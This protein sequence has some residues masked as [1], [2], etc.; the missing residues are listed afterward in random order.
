[1]TQ[2]TP[3]DL[4]SRLAAARQPGETLVAGITGSVAVGKT[5]LARQIADALAAADVGQVAIVSTDGFLLPNAV[6]EPAGLLM[7]KGFPESYDHLGLAAAITGL[8][9]LAA[10]GA[11]VTVPAYSHALYDIDPAG[12]RQIAA[13]DVVLVEGLGLA[14]ADD[15]RRPPLDLLLYIDA[16]EPDVRNWFVE[17]FIGLWAAAANDPASFYARF[18]SMSEAEARAF[19]IT[20]WEGVNL[21][22]WQQ[23]IVRARDVADLVVKKALDHSLVL[24]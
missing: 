9:R 22:N 21:P 17:R 11:P 13:A 12:A 18:R 6:L 10:G 20:V 16:D 7:R 8:K 5:T 4:A 2:I 3:P 23:H 15:G 1:V 14:P 19:A 24:V